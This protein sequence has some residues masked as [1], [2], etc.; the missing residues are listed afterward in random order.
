MTVFKNVNNLNFMHTQLKA[1]G[2]QIINGIEYATCLIPCSSEKVYDE[3]TQATQAM[4]SGEFLELPATDTQVQISSASPNDVYGIGSGAWIVFLLGYDTSFNTQFETLLLN[5][6]APVTSLY[7]YYRFD[8][9][10]V[11]VGADSYG[12]NDGTLYLSAAGATLNGGV[13]A[14]GEKMLTIGLGKGISSSAT[15]S[16]PADTELYFTNYDSSTTAGEEIDVQI[17]CRTGGGANS[18]G[19]IWR[20]IVRFSLSPTISQGGLVEPSVVNVAIPSVFGLG[21]STTDTVIALR[22]KSGQT[23]RISV[24]LLLSGT[25]SLEV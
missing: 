14:F 20:E 9:M 12:A 21:D 25:T 5:G 24:N 19:F 15:L 18:N 6:Q 22:R 4:E 2:T 1:E 10:Q 13:P 16:I 23:D 8:I 3:Y 17:L 7:S 11:I